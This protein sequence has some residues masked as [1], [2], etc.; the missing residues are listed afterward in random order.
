M[1]D[2]KLNANSHDTFEAI[3]RA[4]EC[5]RRDTTLNDDA[6]QRI[7]STLFAIVCQRGCANEKLMFDTLHENIDLIMFG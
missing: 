6:K 1:N 4:I 5:V 7:N 2:V 3:T